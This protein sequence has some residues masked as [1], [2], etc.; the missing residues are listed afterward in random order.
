M[1]ADILGE[2]NELII[3]FNRPDDQ[4]PVDSTDDP[5]EVPSEKSSPTENKGTMMLDATCAPQQI[6]FPQ[7][8]NL[9]NE[10]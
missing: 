8:I 1:T 2:I 9:L 4:P 6:A 5:D 10:A 7:D 3:E